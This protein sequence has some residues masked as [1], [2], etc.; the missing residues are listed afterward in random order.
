MLLGGIV[1]LERELNGKPAGLRTNILICLGAASFTSI[2]MRV[3]A[4]HGDPGRI[5]AQVLTG[6]GF[7]G[8]GAIL[9]T[10]GSVTGLTSAA[11]IWVVAAVGMQLGTASYLEATGTTVLIVLV[12]AGLRSVEGYVARSQ[13]KSHLV[14]HARPDPNPLPDLQAI[15]VRT[16][17]EI[18]TMASRLENVDLVVEMEL[19][20]AKRLHD[21]TLIALVHHPGVRTVSSGE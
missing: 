6:I 10:R 3:G 13:S 14:I 18:L 20:G 12:L 15:V 21:Q 8:A 5:A 7:I 16:G 11:T 19:R 2:S 4:I 17:L 1:G 9:H